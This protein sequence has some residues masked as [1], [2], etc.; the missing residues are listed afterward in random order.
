[1]F[2]FHCEIK[3]LIFRYSSFIHFNLHSYFS[4][5]W[6]TRFGE[7]ALTYTCHQYSNNGASIDLWGFTECDRKF[8]GSSPKELL[9][10][11]F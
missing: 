2:C 1:V 8:V 5:A 7:S 6:E 3:Y 10:S 4:F 9:S 11:S